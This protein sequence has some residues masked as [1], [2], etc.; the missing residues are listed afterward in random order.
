MRS[1]F[2]LKD[3]AGGFLHG[4]E[5]ECQLSDGGHLALEF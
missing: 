3:P 5:R 4:G 1:R 2:T